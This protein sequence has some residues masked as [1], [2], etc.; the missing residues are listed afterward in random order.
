[1]TGR[2]HAPE[3][4]DLT[5]LVKGYFHQDWDVEGESADAIVDK[6]IDQEVESVVADIKADLDSLAAES[7]SEEALE[8]RLVDLGLDYYAPD[9]EGLTYQQWLQRVRERFGARPG[10]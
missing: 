2:D 10:A 3:L 1:M 5:Y 9:A 8:Q 4:P 7:L 6:V